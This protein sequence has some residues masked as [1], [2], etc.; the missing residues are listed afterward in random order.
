[1]ENAPQDVGVVVAWKDGL[2]SLA[3]GKK[4]KVGK[5]SFKEKACDVGMNHG[6]ALFGELHANEYNSCPCLPERASELPTL[7]D[8]LDTATKRQ[9][10][11]SEPLPLSWSMPN[12]DQDV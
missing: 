5:K 2:V 1:M 8:I 7:R 11:P 12:S 3:I 10:P 4:E 9:S 6:M